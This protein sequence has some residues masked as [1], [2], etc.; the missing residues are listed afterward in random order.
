MEENH[1]SLA[2]RYQNLD[3]LSVFVGPCCSQVLAELGPEVRKVE[4]IGYGDFSRHYM[5][6]KDLK[7]ESYAFLSLNRNKRSICLDLPQ[8]DAKEIVFKSV[9]TC[10]VVL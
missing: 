4:S 8:S 5:V 1:G 10:G 3:S 9:K 6:G 7:G 2:G